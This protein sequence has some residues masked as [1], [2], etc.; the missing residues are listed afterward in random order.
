M[1]PSREFR[2]S[3]DT[4]YNIVRVI[5]LI[6]VSL[7][8]QGMMRATNAVQ[9]FSQTL[10]GS[11][12]AEDKHKSK[13]AQFRPSR[14]GLEKYIAP[15][16]LLAICLNLFTHCIVDSRESHVWPAWSTFPAIQ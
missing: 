12:E 7:E 5:F 16:N 10:I 11:A 4:S 14:A 8:L 9:I 1:S 2:A 13:E 15:L 6:V 3:F